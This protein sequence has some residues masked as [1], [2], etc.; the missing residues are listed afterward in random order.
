MLGAVIA[1][2]AGAGSDA[3]QGAMAVAQ[4]TQIQQQINFTRDNEYE[5]DLIGIRALASAGFDPSGMASFFEVMS[6][7]NTIGSMRV[8]EFLKTHPV[9]S[10]RIAEARN[11]A[12]FY[13]TA[14]T[15]DTRNYG[16]S[17]ARLIV[18]GQRSPEDAVKFYTQKEYS[19]LSDEEKYGLALAYQ[20]NGQLQEAEQIFTTLL[21]ANKE[22]IAYHIGLAEILFLLDRK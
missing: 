4:G 10:S 6:G 20:M 2:A 22:V 1:G 3:V 17:K 16:I 19:Y 9:T 13:D 7:T 8:P 18:S 21:D 15:Q 14:D 5:A 11:R 12:R